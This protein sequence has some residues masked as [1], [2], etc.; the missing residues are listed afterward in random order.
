MA[1]GA[2]ALLIKKLPAVDRIWLRLMGAPPESRQSQCANTSRLTGSENRASKF[3]YGLLMYGG[4]VRRRARSRSVYVGHGY[5][6]V[7]G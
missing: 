6:G 3:W 5:L 2:L 1:Y 7:I 4:D